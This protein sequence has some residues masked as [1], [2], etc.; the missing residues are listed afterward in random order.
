MRLH[1]AGTIGNWC[2]S[3][4]RRLNA[5][6]EISS[7]NKKGGAREPMI[8]EER[9]PE[10]PAEQK[11]PSQIGPQAERGTEAAEAFK[12]ISGQTRNM[13][14]RPPHHALPA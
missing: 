3:E 14:D 11:A 5:A 8:E 13:P 7:D 1:S 12:T 4:G 2:R 6:D 9:G 10:D